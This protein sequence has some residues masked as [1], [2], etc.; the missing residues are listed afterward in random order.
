MASRHLKTNFREML[1]EQ[2]CDQQA[3]ML[4]NEVITFAMVPNGYCSIQLTLEMLYSLHNGKEKQNKILPL[5]IRR[6]ASAFGTY[7][8]Q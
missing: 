3:L 2:N 1:L 7:Q 6:S 4:K 5:E 8:S